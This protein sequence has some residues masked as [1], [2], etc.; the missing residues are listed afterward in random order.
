[1]KVDVVNL[2]N[3]FLFTQLCCGNLT[4]RLN[5]QDLLNDLKRFAGENYPSRKIKEFKQINFIYEQ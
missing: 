1:M 3:N 2:G 4:H 5:S